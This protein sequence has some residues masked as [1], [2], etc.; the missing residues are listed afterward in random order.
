M[1]PPPQ[2]Q[3]CLKNAVGRVC[4]VLSLPA[5]FL[6]HLCSELLHQTRVS[7]LCFDSA[8]Q[9]YVLFSAFRG[10]SS[11]VSLCGADLRVVNGNE[12]KLSQPVIEEFMNCQ[13]PTPE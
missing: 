7:A 9:S 13:K 8:G 6:L 11:L 5:A 12:L 3:P 10:F 1:F 2:W 4:L